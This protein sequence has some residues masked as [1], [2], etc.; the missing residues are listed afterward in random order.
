MN[1]PL[2]LSTLFP[3]ANWTMNGDTYA[4]LIWNEVGVPCPTEQDLIDA[5][6]A[7]EEAE[8]TRINREARAAAFRVETDPLYF[9][10]QRGEIGEDTWIDAVADVRLRFPYPGD[11]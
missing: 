6:P 2:I 8:L 1:I 4:D 3:N 5:W 7:V 9:K 11:E 10:V